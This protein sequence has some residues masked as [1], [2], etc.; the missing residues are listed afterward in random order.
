MCRLWGD[1][2][3]TGTNRPQVMIKCKAPSLVAEAD[4]VLHKPC[5]VIVMDSKPLAEIVK[6]DFEFGGTVGDLVNAV[7]RGLNL[8]DGDRGYT[9]QFDFVKSPDH[10]YDG[11]LIANRQSYTLYPVADAAWIEFDRQRGRYRAAW[12]REAT[13]DGLTLRIP[14]VVL[15]GLDHRPKDTVW[16]LL[17]PDQVKRSNILVKITGATTGR[18]EAPAIVQR[19]VDA[20]MQGIADANV[21]WETSAGDTATGAQS[22]D[23]AGAPPRPKRRDVADRVRD[24]HAILK[25]GKTTPTAAFEKIGTDKTT[26][27]RY[28]EGVTGEKPLG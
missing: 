16:D 11:R 14:F 8:L 6:S 12:I 1:L 15:D 3:A 7:N 28:C 20:I 17:P 9:A 23:Q 10:L 22:D 4:G 24:V 18:I 27:R 5:E 25:D 19:A 13:A 21:S 26:Y 2:H